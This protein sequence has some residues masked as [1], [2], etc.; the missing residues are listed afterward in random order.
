MA[1]S[2]AEI[3]ARLDRLGEALTDQ[4]LGRNLTQLELANEAATSISTVRRL[5]AGDNV[6]LEALVRVLD[7]MGLTDRLDL[8]APPVAV[9]P[10]ERVQ[11]GGKE[12]RR[13]RARAERPKMKWTWGDQK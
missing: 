4:R 13:A 11:L 12:R 9:R 2:K 5:E 8:I 6:S 7:A 1:L 3:K 10:V